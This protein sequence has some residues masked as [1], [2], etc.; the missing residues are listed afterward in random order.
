MKKAT[1]AFLVHVLL[2][3]L[4]LATR[5]ILVGMLVY[6]A[7]AVLGS[8]LTIG[9]SFQIGFLVCAAWEVCVCEVDID[10]TFED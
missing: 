8:T 7:V 5:G 9:K 3:I 6:I 2:D 4:V 10:I 1:Y